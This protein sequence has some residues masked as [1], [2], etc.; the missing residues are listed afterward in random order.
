METQ[1]P[2]NNWETISKSEIWSHLNKNNYINTLAENLNTLDTLLKQ[3]KSV[4]DK[5]GNRELLISAH[6]YAPKKYSFLYVFDLQKFAKLNLLKNNLNTLINKNFKVSKRKY[7]AHEIIEIYDIKKHETLY[8]S[9]IQNQIIAS[10][11][12]LLIETSIDKYL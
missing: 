9:F 8:I 1:E 11:V 12:H 10:Y 7:H 6:V 4:F 5:I 2:L 3:Q